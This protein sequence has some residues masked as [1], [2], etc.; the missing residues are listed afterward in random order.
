MV[1]I[2]TIT[3]LYGGIALFL[4]GIILFFGILIALVGDLEEEY[5]LSCCISFIIGVIDRPTDGKLCKTTI[6][7]L[8]S[9]YLDSVHIKRGLANSEI[10]IVPITTTQRDTIKSNECTPIIREITE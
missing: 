4:C 5:I 7:I 8:D 1:L 10:A 2:P 3:L 9:T 6:I